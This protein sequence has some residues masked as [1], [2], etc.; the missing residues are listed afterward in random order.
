MGWQASGRT[1]GVHALVEHD[2]VHLLCGDIGFTVEFRSLSESA[3][4]YFQRIL[5]IS[6]YE[7][8]ETILRAFNLMMMGL[9]YNCRNFVFLSQ[10]DMSKSVSM[11]AN[12]SIL[13]NHA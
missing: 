4:D 8:S 10:N 6:P 12:T 11:L 1:T 2:Q 7:I 13:E 3:N 5:S 9:Q